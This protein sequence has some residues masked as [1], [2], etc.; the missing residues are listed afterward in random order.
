MHE[1]AICQALLSQ[2]EDI[3]RQN[4]AARVTR[5]RLRIGPLSGVVPDLLERTFEVARR[6]TVASQASLV[7]ETTSPRIRCRHCGREATVPVN[8][9]VCPDCGDYRTVLLSGDEL[10]L[11][12]LELQ[13]ENVGSSSPEE[14]GIQT[15]EFEDV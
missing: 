12:S 3:A 14:S 4:D 5:I 15:E 8:R 13:A 2:V 6:G 9:L 1:L 11:A 10:V 7:T